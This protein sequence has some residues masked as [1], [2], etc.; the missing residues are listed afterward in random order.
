MTKAIMKKKWH[1]AD[2]EYCDILCFILRYLKSGISITVLIKHS[3]T[4]SLD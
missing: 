2:L 4:G 3:L 1:K